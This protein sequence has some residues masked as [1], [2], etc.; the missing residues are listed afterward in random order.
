M[1]NSQKLA[2]KESKVL[3]ESLADKDLKEILAHKDQ[4]VIPALLALQD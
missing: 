3:E 4:E 1:A 2:L